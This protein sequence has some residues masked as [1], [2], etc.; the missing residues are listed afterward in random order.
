LRFLR[1]AFAQKRK[2]L[3]NNLRAAGVAPGVAAAAMASAGIAAQA[4]AESVPIEALAALWVALEEAV[5]D[6]R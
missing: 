3:N 1:Q 4:R 6:S 2:T 5:A